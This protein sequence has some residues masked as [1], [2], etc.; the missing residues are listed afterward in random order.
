MNPWYW[1]GY[2]LSKLIGHIFFRYR[3]IHP[4][5]MIQTGPVIL[6]MNHQSYLDPPLAGIA[7]KRPVYF[8]ALGSVVSFSRRI[9]GESERERLAGYVAELLEG[10]VVL[11]TAAAGATVDLLRTDAGRVMERWFSQRARAHWTE[12]CNRRYRV[13]DS[14]L[15]RRAP[16]SCRC[17]FLGRAKPYPAAGA[18]CAFIRSRL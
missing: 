17:E 16:R 7:C 18:D 13:L 12:V 14:S 8:L 5:R 10:G 1:A 11:R 15:P 9:E 2:S 4:E 3:V 6:A